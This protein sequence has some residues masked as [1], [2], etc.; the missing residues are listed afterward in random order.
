M[1]QHK[2]ILRISTFVILLIIVKGSTIHVN[3]NV[4]VD[5][6]QQQQCTTGVDG[7]INCVSASSSSNKIDDDNNAVENNNNITEADIENKQEEP[8]NCESW[9]KHGECINNPTYMLDNCPVSCSRQ[10]ENDNNQ[11]EDGKTNNLKV[12]CVQYA[13]L[14]ECDVNPRF[15]RDACK[16]ECD[17]NDK[18]LLR[19]KSMRKHFTPKQKMAT[20]GKSDTCKLYMAESSIPNSGLGMYT[21]VPIDVGDQV[22]HPEIIVSYFDHALHAERRFMY[23]NMKSSEEWQRVVTGKDNRHKDCMAWAVEEEC[24]ANPDY[25]LTQCAKA[26]ALHEARLMDGFDADKDWLPDSY[27]WDAGNTDSA[28]EGDS[29]DSLV[30]GIGAMANS[31]MGLFNVEMTRA[32]IDSSGMHHSIDPGVGAFSTHY[33]LGWKAT[34][35]IPAGMEIFANY[36]DQW[37]EGREKKFGPLPLSYDFKDA[38]KIL[39]KFFQHTNAEDPWAQDFL[40]LVRN[41]QTRPNLKMAI[42]ETI[43]KANEA[44]KA[45]VGTAMVSVPNVI[46]SEEWLMENGLCLDN[47]RQ[48]QSTILQAGRGAFATRDISEGATI[49]PLSLIH[50]DRDQLKMYKETNNGNDIE[51]EK[52][53]LL[54]NYSYGHEKSS[55]VLFSY[56]PIVNFVNHNFD[57]SKINAKLEW[58]KNKNHKFQWLEKSVEEVI[59]EPYA[60][61][62]LEFVALRD[63]EEG[64]EIFINYGIEWENAWE[65]HVKDWKPPKNENGD[66]LTPIYH[67]NSLKDILTEKEQKNKPYQSHVATICFVRATVMDFNGPSTKWSNFK[68]ESDASNM[69][70]SFRCRVT[71]R[72]KNG[73]SYDVVAQADD[74]ETTAHE[75]VITDVPRHAIEFVNQPYTSD[76]HL[77]NAFRHSIGIPDDIFPSKW[78]DLA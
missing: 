49:A 37:F 64:E 6:Q 52:D 14:G 27:H 19:S 57:H 13:Q 22:F 34:R 9:A 47:I 32:S 26:C 56:S 74:F 16:K 24:T 1:Y 46:R 31:H 72:S 17:N 68:V 69:S 60:G 29:T 30:P 3:A 40:T 65:E 20:I 2:S 77:E 66:H 71:K 50:M 43:E 53:Q 76:Q 48:D 55:L 7:D 21:T 61:L 42:P 25:M 70:D 8:P 58:S 54:L 5:N 67:L 63:I 41:L 73:L 35:A 15:M 23:Q 44:N 18:E 75:V 10:E 45:G 78:M 11:Q 33:N 51:Y 39:R 28:Y 4:E 12:S 62:M 38:N 36:G 59:A